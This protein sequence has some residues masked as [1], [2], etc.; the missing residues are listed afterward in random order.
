[1]LDIQ[2]NLD[3]S[4]AIGLLR[5]LQWSFQG[6]AASR[7]VGEACAKLTRD[8]L[9]RIASSR[10]RSGLARNFYARAADA[11]VSEPVSHGAMITIPHTGL[12]LRYYGGTVRPSGR[13]SL[14]TGRPIKRLAIP[15][16]GRGAEG[17]LPK[18]FK[19]LFVVA[20]KRSGKA[21]LAGRGPSG[22]VRALFTLV[23]SSTHKA[24]KSVL[25]TDDQYT[26]AGADALDELLAETINGF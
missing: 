4:G 17:R 11:V 20:S 23:K 5:K 14:V 3:G 9:C 15:I 21:V 25:P 1:M 12:A 19:G 24:D 2:V 6:R 8:H 7:A 18:D 22:L 26:A 16:K 10:H 13:V